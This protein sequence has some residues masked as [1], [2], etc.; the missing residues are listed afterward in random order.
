MGKGQSPRTM[1]WP[2]YYSPPLLCAT[3]LCHSPCGRA[4]GVRSKLYKSR[5][6]RAWL[7]RETLNTGLT[8]PFP[9]PTPF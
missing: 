3:L 7:G 4:G 9:A 2:M 1:E 5:S 8:Y 6:T